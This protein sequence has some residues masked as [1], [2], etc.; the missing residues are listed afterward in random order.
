M[1][2]LDRFVFEC[3]GYLVIE[4]VLTPD[5]RKETLEAAFVCTPGIRRPNCFN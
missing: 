1:T 2:D 3:Y 5:E 4:D